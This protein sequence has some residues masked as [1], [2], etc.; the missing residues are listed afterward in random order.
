LFG[1]VL[2]LAVLG[3]PGAFANSKNP[4]PKINYKK[5]Y[6]AKPYDKKQKQS[7]ITYGMPKGKRAPKS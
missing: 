6:V 3:V 5:R 1:F 2:L 4:G 7:T